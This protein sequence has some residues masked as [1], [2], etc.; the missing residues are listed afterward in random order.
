MSK[1]IEDGNLEKLV[2]KVIS[3][4]QTGA[5]MAG[6]RAAKFC[7]IETGGTA[8]LHFMTE[9]GPNRSLYHFG[10]RE[11]DTNKVDFPRRT[12]KNIRNSDGTIIF[13]EKSSRGSNL[14]E[15]IC[16]GL[17]KPYWINPSVDDIRMFVATHEIEILNVAGNRES[18]SPGIEERV[19]GLLIRAFSQSPL[20]E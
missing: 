8:P 19:F 7:H 5:D 6:L 18:V 17:R 11:D 20:E 13:K 2:K 14:T 1:E 16:R 4:G 9:D 12:E 15:S 3:G 10:L